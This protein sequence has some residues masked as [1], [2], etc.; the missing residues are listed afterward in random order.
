[1]TDEAWPSEIRLVEG[2]RALVVVFEDGVRH[3]FAAEHLRVRT[4]S[5]EVQGHSAAD[6]KTLG[7]KRNVLIRDVTPVGNYAVRL[8]FDDGHDTG[9]FTWRFF[10]DLGPRQ[11]E[12][13]VAYERELTKKGLDRDRPGEA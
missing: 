1:M 4:P 7:G 5:A 6:R 12:D 9:L 13:F 3:H 2:G 11:A 10:R 8:D